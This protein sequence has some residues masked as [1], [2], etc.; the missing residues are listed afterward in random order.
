MGTKKLSSYD[1]IFNKY[2]D[3]DITKSGTKYEILA[4]MVLK[5]LIDAGKV[6]HDIKLLGESDVKHQ[7]D[8]LFEDNGNN[9]RT[10]IECK[11]YDISEKSVGLGVIRDFS[12]V[13]DDIKPDEAFILTCNDFTNDAKK[14]AKCKKIKLAILRD[15][16][17]TDKKGCIQKIIC[18]LSILNSTNP[19]VE[20]K[21]DDAYCLKLQKDLNDEQLNSA[22]LWKGQPLFL[23]TAEGRF[24]LNEY[25]ERIW[26]A[27]PRDKEGFV[28]SK[29]K[30]NNTTIEVANRGGVPVIGL[31]LRFEVIHNT[32][33]FEIV[34]DKIAEL[35]LEG[36][37]DTEIIIFDKDIQK[38]DIDSN[39]GEI[40]SKRHS[41]KTQI[42]Q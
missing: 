30:L 12:A 20:I 11:D 22:G 15:F 21:I 31:I 35:V 36:F 28:E 40:I 14:F 17:E 4:A 34:S 33:V 26:N 9:K 24:Q 41:R 13:V 29:H 23:N 42:K 6:I 8:V 3:K 10:L 38:Y 32:E 25:V 19:K 5:H 37:S 39:T 7:I 27:Y 1:K 2:F 16:T 18:N